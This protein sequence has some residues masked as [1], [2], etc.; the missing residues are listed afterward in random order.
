M[1]VLRL[2]SVPILLSV[3]LVLE[4][5]P[6]R[7]IIKEEIPD[8][9]HIVLNVA[10]TVAAPSEL[11]F[12]SA[13]QR[14]LDK[15]NRG[16][17]IHYIISHANGSP[18]TITLEIQKVRLNNRT[19]QF[20]ALGVDMFGLFIVPA[21]LREVDLPIRRFILPPYDRTHYTAIY[22]SVEGYESKLITK[23][24]GRVPFFEN[25]EKQQLRQCEA[26]AGNVIEIL[27]GVAVQ[28]R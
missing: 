17:D 8:T 14:E 2:Q 13:L 24:A 27:E 25:E 5:T 23:A 18:S 20:I 9:L 28:H 22:H 26:F 7:L 16:S 4:C 1:D 12:T 3:L 21:M 11:Q 10:E 6:S 15:F 19:A